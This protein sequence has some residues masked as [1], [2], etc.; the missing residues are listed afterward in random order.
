MQR[1]PSHQTRF[2]VQLNTPSTVNDAL[3][4][5][6]IDWPGGTTMPPV[7]TVSKGPGER[8]IVMK[9]VPPLTADVEERAVMTLASALAKLPF[10]GVRVAGEA[11]V[12]PFVN[13]TVTVKLDS[14]LSEMPVPH[15]G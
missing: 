5:M 7:S 8:G 9:G 12:P 10:T 2:T 13:A 15:T 6:A 4:V 1:Q 11:S 14:R 3:T